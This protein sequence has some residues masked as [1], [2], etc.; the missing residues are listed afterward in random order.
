MSTGDCSSWWRHCDGM[1]VY[2]WRDMEYLIHL[3]TILTGDRYVSIPS[4]HLHPFMSIVHSDG[5]GEFQQ[6]NMR[7]PTRPKLLQSGSRRT[8][9]NLDT[10]TGHQNPLT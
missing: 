9:Q 4:E 6:D 3:D 2:S 7:H 10:S 5:L 1:G 8:L